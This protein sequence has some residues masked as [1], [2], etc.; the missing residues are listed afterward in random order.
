[1]ADR[2]KFGRFGPGNSFGSAGGRA[3]AERLTPEQRRE[4][5]RAGW[6]GLVDKRFGGDEDAAREW[7]AALGAW[8]SQVVHGE[9]FSRFEHPGPCPGRGRE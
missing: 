3:R 6:R 8:A 4:I 1:M 9:F 2:G 5:G 7:F